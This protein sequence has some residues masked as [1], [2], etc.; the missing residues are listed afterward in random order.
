MRYKK[1]IAFFL[2]K[3]VDHSKGMTEI[4]LDDL[5]FCKSGCVLIYNNEDD[6]YRIRGLPIHVI[7]FLS[8]PFIGN[9]SFEFHYPGLLRRLLGE[10]K[11]QSYYCSPATQMKSWI[12][13][14]GEMS[15][16]NT[17]KFLNKLWQT[18]TLEYRHIQFKVIAL[19]SV[20]KRRHRVCKD[21]QQMIGRLSYQKE[22]EG[23]R[24]QWK[25]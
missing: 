2:V 8:R 22:L 1:E 4:L 3:I 20:L 16:E 24:K 19:M 10:T 11:F 18:V 25:T 15:K 21:M 17:S 6:G 5:Q 12:V 23:L 9:V 7:L 13:F 14:H